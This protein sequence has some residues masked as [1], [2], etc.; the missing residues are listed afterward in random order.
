MVKRPKELSRF[1]VAHNISLFSFLETKVKMGYLGRLYQN[2][3]PGWCFSHNL[4]YHHGVRIIFGW[5][6]SEMNVNI[7]FMSS[8]I[9]HLEITPIIGEVFLCSFVY[10]DNTASNRSVLFHQ[11]VSLHV[12][13]P[14]LVM[15]DFNCLAGLDECTGHAVR[16][17]ETI[18]LRRCMET[19]GLHDLRFHGCFFTWSNKRSE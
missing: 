13:G 10:G 5:K 8:Q 9:V 2:L 12:N 6:G 15:G 18:P 11:L 17:Q 7:L 4:P 1:L 14:W 19:C 16:L 3:C